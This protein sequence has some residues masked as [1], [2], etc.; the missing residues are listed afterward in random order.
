MKKKAFAIMSAVAM[1]G[2]L[3]AS[4]A[5]AQKFADDPGESSVRVHGQ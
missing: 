3:S 1:C 5:Y 4:T 2:V